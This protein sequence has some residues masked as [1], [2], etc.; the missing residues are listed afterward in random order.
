MRHLLTVVVF[1]LGLWGCDQSSLVKEKLE[2]DG[3]TNVEVRKEG[4][5]YAF[6]AVKGRQQCTGTA[7]VTGISGNYTM[8][9][10]TQC[11]GP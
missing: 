2:A 8:E 7:N 1:A 6:K 3:Y 5:G 4:D 10:Q 9:M 11:I